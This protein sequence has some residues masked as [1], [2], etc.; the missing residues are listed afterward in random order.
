MSLMKKLIDK[1]PFPI[2]EEIQI[3]E[4]R[5]IIINCVKIKPNDRIS[6]KDL[7]NLIKEKI[8]NFNQE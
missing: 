5:E 7:T 4:I 1:N 8:N 2:P 6:A 3:D